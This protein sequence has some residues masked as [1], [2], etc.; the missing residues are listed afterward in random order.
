MIGIISDTHDNT[1]NV[2][3]AVQ[4]FKKNKVD[5]VIHCGDLCAPITL[6]YFEGLIVHFV[7][8][9]VDGAVENIKRILQAMN[10]FYYDNIL[11]MEYKGKRI[12]ALHYNETILKQMI[13]SQ[14]YDYIFHGHTHKIRDEKIGRTRII[15]PGT[16][17]MAHKENHFIVLLDVEKDKAEFVKIE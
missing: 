13:D 16:Q 10:G 2:Q 14:K 8:G 1:Q 7:R 17:Y 11:D 9:N 5:F 4:I 6:K 12:A 15:N 3:K